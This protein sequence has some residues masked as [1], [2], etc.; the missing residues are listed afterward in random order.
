MRTHNRGSLTTHPTLNMCVKVRHDAICVPFAFLHSGCHLHPV[1]LVSGDKSNVSDC[2]CGA[3]HLQTSNQ[4]YCVQRMINHHTHDRITVPKSALNA[5]T[6][7]PASTS[8]LQTLL[9]SRP[10]ET[11]TP[12]RLPVKAPLERGERE[13]IVVSI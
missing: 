9:E 1:G 11:Q 7:N 6:S 13:L 5:R 4:K 2:A 12:M 10:P 8:L 3:V